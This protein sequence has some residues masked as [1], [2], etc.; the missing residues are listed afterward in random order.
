MIKI[1]NK[2]D[3]CGCSACV[4]KCPKTCIRMKPDEE[5][6]LYPSIDQ[7]VCVDCGL[8][9]N[10]CP[11]IN[12]REERVPVITLAVK[13][14]N[15]E[16]RLKSSSGGVFSALAIKVL[17]DGGLVFGAKFNEK[18]EVVHDC[19][20]EIDDLHLFQGS[21]YVQSAI[22]ETFSQ[23]KSFLRKGKIVLFSGTPCQIAGLKNFLGEEYLNLLTVEVVCHGTPSPMIWRDYLHYLIVNQKIKGARSLSDI[24]SIS[25]RSKVTG[26]KNFS[27]EIRTAMGNS[28]RETFN[29]NIFMKGF[30]NN[31]YLRPS[32]Y[33]CPA[34]KGRSGADISLADF[35]GVSNLHK[36]IDDDKGIGLVFAN[37]S[38]GIDY[39]ES[40][41]PTLSS[42]ESVYDVAVKYNPCIVTNVEEPLSREDF[43]N[44]YKEKKIYAIKSVCK[45]LEPSILKRC[46]NVIK[47]ILRTIVL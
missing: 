46:I 26:W 11:V 16:I 29:A 13:N 27:F 15:E 12:K 10:V 37:S 23:A 43:F 24:S 4:Q 31:L 39:L 38:S 44:D 30:L 14:I 47:A 17:K 45:D 1:Q 18:W 41:A 8:C 42:I 28:F 36:R 2:K 9:E 25:F 20:E 32:C 5:G 40:I 33:C 34:R 7:T 3:C 6:F 35:W 21:K 22:G 19:I